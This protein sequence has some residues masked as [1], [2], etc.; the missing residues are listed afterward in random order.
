M[1]KL[2][3]ST[4]KMNEHDIKLFLVNTA[5]MT[6]S[7]AQVETALKLALLLVSIGYTLQRWHFLR[8]NKGK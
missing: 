7:M 3:T 4:C 6:I 1:V 5:A 2:G 8:K